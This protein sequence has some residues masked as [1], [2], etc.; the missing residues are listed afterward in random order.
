MF[1]PAIKMK[2]ILKIY[3]ATTALLLIFSSALLENCQASPTT[4]TSTKDKANSTYQ[5]FLTNVLDIDL[6]QYNITKSGYGVS[7]PAV[8]GGLKTED[9][10]YT[11]D[12]PQ[13]QIST[14]CVIENG[15]VVALSLNSLGTSGPVIYSQPQAT[16]TMDVAKS[17]LQKLQ[18]FNSQVGT[19][20][21]SHIEQARLSLD[22]ENT[23][24]PVT[25]IVG[26]MQLTIALSPH[27]ITFR[28]D[29][30]QNGM[31]VMNKNIYLKIVNNS[32]SSFGDSWNRYSISDATIISEEEAKSYAF[33]KLQ[34]YNV[35]LASFQ[36]ETVTPVQF[37]PD[38]SHM[39]YKA[40]LSWAPG[41]VAN[42]D[43][44]AINTYNS[45][46][47]RDPFT[48]YPMWHFIFYFNEP[49]GNVVGFEANVWADTKELE[50]CR[51]Y[52][53]LGSMPSLPTTITLPTTTPSQQQNTQLPTSNTQLS[54]LYEISIT[55]A[56]LV[57]I[58]ISLLIVK[59]KK[60]RENH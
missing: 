42:A 14:W 10:S 44:L 52:G 19:Q 51:E 35:T 34:E 55:S 24:S 57:A 9:L 18:A 43:P 58:A 33:S 5:T 47:A 54:P 28:W 20:D 27:W 7:Y 53:Y 4:D 3:I 21:N 50:M 46:T 1:C 40:N 31:V 39:T 2:K 37:K 25:K 17:F 29:Y 56:I 22:N 6:T 15:T 13:G 12:S 60:L 49:I 59:R 11:L 30:V 48:L 32:V 36:G 45:S 8:S 38:W 23:Q 26:D 41:N 16:N